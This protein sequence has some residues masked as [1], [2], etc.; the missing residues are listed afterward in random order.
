MGLEDLLGGFGDDTFDRIKDVVQL[1]D[2][3]RDELLGAVGFISNHG[4]DLLEVVEFVREH[5]DSL[6]DL[7]G[8]LPE[9]MAQAGEALSSASEAAVSASGFLTAGDGTDIH[10]VASSAGAAID[11]C[12]RHLGSVAGLLAKV[13]E[14]LGDIRIPTIDVERSELMGLSVVSGLDVGSKPIAAGTASDVTSGAQQLTD[15]VAAL[16]D[17]G[18]GL[19][20][21]HTN[22]SAAG[23][24]IAALAGDIDRSGAA[25]T[26]LSGASPAKKRPAK[27]RPAAKKKPAKK[28]PAAKKKPVAKKRPA[29]KKKPARKK[30]ARKKPAR[31]KPARTKGPG[32]GVLKRG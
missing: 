24:R 22:L 9:L 14:E 23:E 1:V 26:A 13:G 11:V 16:G 5:G 30:P 10:D 32:G 6:I 3:N 19:D 28:R 15:V 4:E 20:R 21:L 31:K 27:K 29:A 12:R 8:R 17:A 2:G 25:L 7:V 18:E